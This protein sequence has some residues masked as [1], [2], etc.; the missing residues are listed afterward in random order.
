MENLSH[1]RAFALAHLLAR[2]LAMAEDLVHDTIEKALS[3]RDQFTPGTNLKAWLITNM[4][5]RIHNLMRK[6]SRRAEVGFDQV[7][8]LRSIDGGQE[9]S[10]EIQEFHTAFMKLPD[11]QREALI[12]VGASGLS[13]EEIAEVTGVAVGTVKSRISRARAQLTMELDGVEAPP[14][15]L[16]SSI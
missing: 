13:Y 3:N 16:L 4:R 5:H 8:D 2:D 11:S 12:L 1:L 6:S 9:V 7:V 15:W 14:G 10:I